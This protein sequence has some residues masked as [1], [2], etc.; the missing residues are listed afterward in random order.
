MGL[1][2]HT[3][4]FEDEGKRNFLNYI[5]ASGISSMIQDLPSNLVTSAGGSVEL[6]QALRPCGAA[7]CPGAQQQHGTLLPSSRNRQY[8][9]Q[10]LSGPPDTLHWWRLCSRHSNQK[11]VLV[12]W[13][14]ISRAPCWRHH[15][16]IMWKH[17]SGCR[18]SVRGSR[19]GVSFLKQ[20]T[21]K[22]LRLEES[23]IP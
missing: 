6:G 14:S 3:P 18:R 1:S 16:E 4:N 13:R 5:Q 7:G 17:T 12:I 9:Q 11:V 20:E 2:T 15:P 8:L 21:R 19:L 23:V 10:C 22:F